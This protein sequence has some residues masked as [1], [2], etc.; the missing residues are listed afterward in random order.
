VSVRQVFTLRVCC[1]NCHREQD[2]QVTD[3]NPN[4]PYR[5]HNRVLPPGWVVHIEEYPSSDHGYG[6][7][8]DVYHYCPS[9]S[10]AKGLRSVKE[11]DKN[12]GSSY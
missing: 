12:E 8:S 5:Y 2:F 10:L 4:S 1:S 6:I 9:C 11:G 3:Y 7:R